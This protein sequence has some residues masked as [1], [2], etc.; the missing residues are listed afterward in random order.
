MREKYKAYL[1]IWFVLMVP[2]MLFLL[3][4]WNFIMCGIGLMVGLLIIGL[5]DGFIKYSKNI[6]KLWGISVLLD[7][8]AFIF[9]LAPE[10]LSKIEFFNTN[11]VHPLEYN[12]Y[13][14]V[15]STIYIIILFVTILFL[16]YKLINKFIIKGINGSKIKVRFMKF[17]IIISVLPYL[18]FI[19]STFVI[20]T[21]KNNLEDF[22]GTI[23]GNKSDVVTVMKYLSVSDYIDS[24]VLDTHT[25]PYSINLYLDT[26]DVN[27]M[28]KFEM[29]AATIFNLIEDVNAVNYTMNGIKYSYS[30]NKINKIFKDV[31]NTDISDILNR[32]TSS[33]YTEY[34]YLDHVG[35]YD[36]F[37]TSEVCEETNQRLFTYNGNTY[38][39]ECS[40]LENIMLFY[41]NEKIM[42]LKTA[43]S[44]GAISEDDIIDSLL[45][46]KTDEELNENSGI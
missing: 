39:L 33:N 13:S 4:G 34:M 8:I 28:E 1:P 27:Y 37:D 42:D 45:P 40:S 35:K 29:D 36:L 3:I 46:I 12:P 2:P 32:Y 22:K 20:Q 5:P 41:A 19:P 43:L 9:L 25:E 7:V 17:V 10:L 24:Y 31:K 38:Y 11:L 26:I 14:K 44:Q 6:F 21:E 16:A 15:F 30:I 18:L 23:L